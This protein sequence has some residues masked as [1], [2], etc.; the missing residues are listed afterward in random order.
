MKLKFFVLITLLVSSFA[1]S[2]KKR[3]NNL[4]YVQNTV[5]GFKNIPRQKLDKVKFLK[6]IGFDGLEGAGYSDYYELKSDLDQVG[7]HMPTNYVSLSFGSQLSKGSASV[8]EIKEMI[9]GAEKGSIVYF[10]VQSEDFKYDKVAGDQ[11]L[12]VILQELSDFASL[13]DVKLC[14]YPHL[15]LYCETLEHSLKLAKLV[16]RSNF[17]CVINLCH[18]LKIEGADGIE[19][20][21]KS[22][23]PYLFAVNICGADGGN[24]QKLDWNKLIQPLGEGSFDTYNFL[25]I[26]WDAGYKGPVGLQCYNLK[27][28][29]SVVLKGSFQTWLD[30]KKRYLKQ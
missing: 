21:V 13:Y 25:R 11:L 26:I 19:Q 1:I 3:V 16:S 17:G 22:L 9:K 18:L 23:M 14:V 28:E 7:W 24:T 2:A 5:D 29:A 15:S 8:P 4:F 20:K 10:N 6:S 30:Y 12:S 27:G